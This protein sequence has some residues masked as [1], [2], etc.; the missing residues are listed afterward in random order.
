VCNTMQKVNLPFNRISEAHNFFQPSRP[1]LVTTLEADEF[2]HVAPFSW[3]IPLSMDPPIVGMALLAKPK[4]QHSLENIERHPEFV[5][6]VPGIELAEQLVICSYK[7]GPGTKKINAAKLGHTPANTVKP[8]LIAECRAHLE[9]CVSS[10]QETGDHC[11]IIGKVVNISYNPG[12][13][14]ADLI[15]NMNEATPCL[16]LT[17]YT[18]EDGQAHLFL[19]PSGIRLVDVPYIKRN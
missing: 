1:V 4:K 18:K 16:H 13:Y 14:T 8:N 10:I 15:M 19:S 12:S 6:N 9:C 7:T 2:T 11:L 5:V 3:V 17:S